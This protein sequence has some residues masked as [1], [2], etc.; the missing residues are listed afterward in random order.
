MTTIVANLECM[1]ADQRVSAEGAPYYH[2]NKIFRIGNSLFGTAGD[3]FMS[4]LMIDWLKKGAKN[5]AALYKLWTDYERSAFWLLEL[6]P[7]GLFLWD[8][9]AIPEKLNDTRYAIGSGA[10]AAVG[11]MDSGKT[12]EEAVKV[13]TSLDVY[14]G[15]PIQVEY[16]LPPELSPRRRKTKADTNWRKALRED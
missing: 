4:L 12:P 10:L 5:R 13:A 16:L 6:N 15:A 14:S 1:A 3:G 8:G 7:N 11:A 9:W 2:A